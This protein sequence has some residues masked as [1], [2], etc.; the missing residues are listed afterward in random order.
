MEQLSLFEETQQ[1]E[2]EVGSK[3]WCIKRYFELIKY[4]FEDLEKLYHNI[5]ERYDEHKKWASD[6]DYYTSL[7][8]IDIDHYYYFNEFKER[9]PKANVY[10]KVPFYLEEQIKL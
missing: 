1:K 7:V 2:L 6:Y 9:Y 3:E 8:I 4:S 5:F 10:K